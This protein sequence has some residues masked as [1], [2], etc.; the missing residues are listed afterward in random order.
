M[1][2]KSLHTF[3][4]SIVAFFA[5]TF[6]I[7]PAN[8]GEPSPWQLGFQQAATPVK[9]QLNDFHNM[10][11]III[12]GIT[13]FVLG[14]LLYVMFRF[15]AKSNPEPSKTT[16]NVAIE[17]I[18]TVVPVIILVVIAIPSFQILYYMDRVVEPEMTLEVEGYQ[19]GWTYSYPDHEEITFDADMIADEEL[20]E[21]IPEGQ[22][23]R[24]LE[25]YNPVVIPAETNIEIVV[26]A[27]PKDVLHSWAMPSFGV[28]K[29][30]VPGRI[31]STWINV[32]KPGVYFG[33]CS[34]LCGERH[35]YMPISIYAVEKQE[36]DAWVNCVQND[37]ADEFYP[38]RAC[39]QELGFDKYRRSLDDV[40]RL[41][42]A[43]AAQQ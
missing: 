6:T 28:K 14:L 10:L 23:R 43:T 21:F 30:A 38:S 33:Q 29:D 5:V 22:G 26:T 24:L 42:F 17:I 34:E 7:L 37:K 19:W 40:N 25:T 31:N 13:V 39:V 11:L 20:D 15:N 36:F 4:C 3:C 8:A 27:R 18:W 2:I 32:N 9:E 12:T 1:M 35:A 41:K 16:H